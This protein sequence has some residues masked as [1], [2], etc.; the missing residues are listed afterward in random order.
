MKP[1]TLSAIKCQLAKFYKVIDEL[2]EYFDS[3][4]YI[5]IAVLLQNIAF[6]GSDCVDYDHNK[7]VQRLYK[8]QKLL[9][10]IAQY[11]NSYIE[12]WVSEEVHTIIQGEMMSEMLEEEANEPIY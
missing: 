12:N 11:N 10:S 3:P 7:E 6:N 5:T 8:V 4:Q 2:T 9:K 1:E